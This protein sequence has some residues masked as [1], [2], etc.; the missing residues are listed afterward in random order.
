[1]KGEVGGEVFEIAMKDVDDPPDGSESRVKIKLTTDWKV[2]KI[3][4]KKFLT[5]NMKRIMVPMAFVFEG[6]EGKKIHVRSIQFK[7]D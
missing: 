6:S 7:K 4:T 2:Y 1:M 5:A 3:E